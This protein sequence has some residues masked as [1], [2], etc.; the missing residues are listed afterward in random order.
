MKL[1]TGRE[2]ISDILGLGLQARGRSA[3]GDLFSTTLMDSAHLHRTFRRR[4]ERGELPHVIIPGDL[5][6]EDFFATVATFYSAQVPISA[7]VHVLGGGLE[8]LFDPDRPEFSPAE[9]T[10]DFRLLTLLGASLGETALASLNGPDGVPNASYSGCR[11]SL[12]Y[13]LARATALYPKIDPQIVVDRWV[14]LRHLTGLTV[15]PATVQAVLSLHAASTV[16]DMNENIQRSGLPA[17]LISALGIYF[18]THGNSKEL[19]DALVEGYPGLLNVLED[20]AGP[21]DARMTVFMNG[22]QEIQKSSC[23]SEI[24]SLAV[25]FL[26]NSIFPGSFAHGRILARLIDFYPSALIWYGAFTSASASFEAQNFSN[27]LVAKLFRDVRQ[28]FSFDERPLCDL[29]LDELDVLARTTIKA[30]SLKS[31]HQKTALIALIPGVDILSRVFSDE[32]PQSRDS[33][34]NEQADDRIAHATRLLDEASHLLRE[35]ARERGVSVASTGS[36]R[37]P[38]K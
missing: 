18:K 9:S 22:I 27:G 2:P 15:N 28:R 26:C 12:A 14:H 8:T 20:M 35:I 31:S 23:D 24:D 29:S 21:F 3:P 17:R 4:N 33:V 34:R 5:N 11:R 7:Y 36:T 16:V 37:R 6:L 19:T 30:Q 38:R 32:E 1:K 25:A 10:S 13:A